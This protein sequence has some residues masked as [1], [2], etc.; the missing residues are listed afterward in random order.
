MATQLK[1]N[2]EFLIIPLAETKIFDLKIIVLIIPNVPTVPK[3][4]SKRTNINDKNDG[5]EK[6]KIDRYHSSSFLEQKTQ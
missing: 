2:R 1:D 3:I 5:T 6:K 4:F